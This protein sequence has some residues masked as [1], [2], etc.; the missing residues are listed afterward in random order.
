VGSQVEVLPDGLR[1]APRALPTGKSVDFATHSD[2]RMAMS[3]TLLRLG[4]VDVRLDDPR[5][6]AKSFPGFFDEWAKVEQGT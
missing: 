1:I 6:V 4:G 2:H 3:F 5:C